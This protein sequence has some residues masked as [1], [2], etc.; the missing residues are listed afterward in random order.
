MNS[1]SQ[2]CYICKVIKFT[3]LCSKVI[4]TTVPICSNNPVHSWPLLDLTMQVAHYT[5][6]NHSSL[7]VW[8]LGKLS[9]AFIKLN[10][11]P[12][13]ITLFF[14]APV[15]YCF[16]DH[17]KVKSACFCSVGIVIVNCCI[18]MSLKLLVLLM[19]LELGY[20]QKLSGKWI[21]IYV[22]LS[23]VVVIWLHTFVCV[24]VCVCVY[25]L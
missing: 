21:H 13:H 22:K 14:V 20:S 17:A 6:H 12:I 10:Q 5:Q 24:C 11:Q 8:Q 7:L 16:G 1:E 23:V 3:I 19:S 15:L 25:S 9:H 18:K 4:Y 2:Y